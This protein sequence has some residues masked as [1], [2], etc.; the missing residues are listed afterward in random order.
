MKLTP[1][2]IQIYDVKYKSKPFVKMTSSE[3]DLSINALLLKIHAITGWAIPSN[4]IMI[5]FIDQFKKKV[6]EDYPLVNTDEVEFAF[7]KFGLEVKDWGKSMNLSLIDEV[8]RPYLE[9]RFEV[10]KYEEIQKLVEL[11]APVTTNLEKIQECD[12]WEQKKEI[13]MQYIP[14]Y[15]YDYLTECGRLNLT[16]DEKL[17]YMD[18][19]KKYRLSK[20]ESESQ[21]DRSLRQEFKNLSELLKE[22]NLIGEE[23]QRLKNLAKKIAEIGRAHV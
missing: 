1:E 20:L 3:L 23:L 8:L 11:P 10:S 22:N 9:M 16:K 6:I 2:E 12:E 21:E 15:L 14:L 4:E 18:K 5:I 13:R 19:A 17:S 7:R